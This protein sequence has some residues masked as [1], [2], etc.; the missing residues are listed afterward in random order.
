MRMKIQR[1]SLKAHRQNCCLVFWC[2]RGIRSQCDSATSL[3]I[4]FGFAGRAIGN[5]VTLLLAI[6]AEALRFAA[7]YL[8]LSEFTMLIHFAIEFWSRSRA[9]GSGF[10]SGIGARIGAIRV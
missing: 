10:G 7:L 9:I 3:S 8:C 1:S 5:K 2:L 6:H 4:F